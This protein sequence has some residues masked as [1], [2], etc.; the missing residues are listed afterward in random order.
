[1]KS[2]TSTH[3]AQFKNSFVL[4]NL[5]DSCAPS[6]STSVALAV[7]RPLVPHSYSRPR[8]SSTFDFSVSIYTEGSHVPTNRFTQAQATHMP[9]TVP[10]VSR[11]RRNLSRSPSDNWL[12]NYFAPAA[13]LIT[14]STYSRESEVTQNFSQ[15]S[16]LG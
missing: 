1:M 8:G 15:I 2:V 3:L 6:F 4:D 16:V 11:S 10:P 13:G 7:F 12:T 14:C 9:D 5:A